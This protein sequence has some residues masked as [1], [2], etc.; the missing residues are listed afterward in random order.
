MNQ[1]K[2]S[3]MTE[4]VVK[5]VRKFVIGEGLYKG[6]V[7]SEAFSFTNLTNVEIP[8]KIRFMMGGEQIAY[9]LYDTEKKEYLKRAEAPVAVT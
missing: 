9:F 2:G 3:Q 8:E 6:D 7:T 1:K 4:V 5:I